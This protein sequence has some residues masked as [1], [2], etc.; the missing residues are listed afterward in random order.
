MNVWHLVLI[1]AVGTIAGFLNTVA[2][3]GS[4]VTMP[5]LIFLGL[6]SQWRT[7]QSRRNY[8]PEYCRGGKFSP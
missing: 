1:A 5:M 4:L 2:G 6:P 3:G 8:G 7:D